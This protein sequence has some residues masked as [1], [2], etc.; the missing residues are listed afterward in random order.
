MNTEETCLVRG[1]WDH[2]PKFSNNS[3]TAMKTIC[4]CNKSTGEDLHEVGGRSSF[5]LLK[6]FA[7]FL[8]VVLLFFLT[9][10]QNHCSLLSD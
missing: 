2:K 4:G 10:N 6:A 8:V 9:I 7:C 5:K 1:S 3:K